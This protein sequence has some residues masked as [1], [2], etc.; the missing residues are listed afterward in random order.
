MPNKYVIYK[1]Y[2]K[3][4][5]ILFYLFFS[6]LWK[7]ELLLKLGWYEFLK[8][9]KKNLEDIIKWI[10]ISYYEITQLV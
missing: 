6:V 9:L 10:E 1:R 2:A 4:I 8:Q 7:Q 3:Q 5:W